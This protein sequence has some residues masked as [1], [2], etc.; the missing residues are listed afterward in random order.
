[1]KALVSTHLGLKGNPDIAESVMVLRDL[2]LAHY[3]G[4]ILHVPHVTTKKQWS[5]LKG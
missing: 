5:T 1:M 3:T 2:E 4:A